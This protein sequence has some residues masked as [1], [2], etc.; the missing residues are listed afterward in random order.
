MGHKSLGWLAI[1]L[2]LCGSGSAAKKPRI[3]VVTI[4]DRKGH[5]LG[6]SALQNKLLSLVRGAGYEGVTLNFQP[7]ADVEAQARQARCDYILYTDVVDVHR[8]AGTQ[9]SNAGSPSRRRDIWEAEVE[10]RIFA[11]DRVQPLLST[12]VTAKNTKSRPGTPQA[13]STTPAPSMSV[14]EP[15]LLTEATPREESGRQRK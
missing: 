15:N 4:Q 7:A 6:T 11:L 1:G 8:T 13:T 14:G 2:C 3:G 9:V 5:G 10:F 12:S